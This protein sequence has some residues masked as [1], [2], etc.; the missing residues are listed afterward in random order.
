MG[1][2]KKE[3][4]TS[5]I[6]IH[7]DKELTDRLL[8]KCAGLGISKREYVRKLISEDLGLRYIPGHYEE[9]M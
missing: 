2:I 1:R 4:E 6:G 9:I 5:M 8:I 3:M 7:L